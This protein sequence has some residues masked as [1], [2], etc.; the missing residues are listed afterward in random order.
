MC[1]DYRFFIQSGTAQPWSAT[2]DGRRSPSLPQSCCAGL[3]DCSDLR[4]GL[5][6]PAPR[7]S[8]WSCVGRM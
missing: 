5:L 1:Q 2:P 6:Q 7:S 3:G 8:C 4:V